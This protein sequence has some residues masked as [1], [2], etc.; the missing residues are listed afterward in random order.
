M[1]LGA[2]SLITAEQA[3]H[4]SAYLS[5]PVRPR[6]PSSVVPRGLADIS[7]YRGMAES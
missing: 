1:M 5:S 7:L 3:E 6:F 4:P 2:Q